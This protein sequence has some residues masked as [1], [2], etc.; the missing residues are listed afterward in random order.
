[1]SINVENEEIIR[2][3]HKDVAKKH[4]DSGVSSSLELSLEP[5]DLLPEEANTEEFINQ[6]D[7]INTLPDGGRTQG[8]D[9]SN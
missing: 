7:G 9:R 6:N 2:Q 5:Q 4:R 3:I 8:M 1:M